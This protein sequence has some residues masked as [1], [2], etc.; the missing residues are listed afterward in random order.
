MLH[1][2]LTPPRSWLR[3]LH[4][5]HLPWG[6]SRT[7]HGPQ[8][9]HNLP[10]HLQALISPHSP[11]FSAPATLVSS[12]FLKHTYQAQAT[13]LRAFRQAAPSNICRAP[14][15]ASFRSLF[16][17]R[18]SERPAQTRLS[19]LAATPVSVRL[20][21]VMLRNKQPLYLDSSLL[22]HATRPSQLGR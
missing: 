20:G 6:K 22:P 12:L 9:Q 3:T 4:G 21:E 2:Y 1:A 15:L 7:Q 5:S 11:F 14:P 17:C 16:K 18:S 19:K 10:C 8:A 13:S